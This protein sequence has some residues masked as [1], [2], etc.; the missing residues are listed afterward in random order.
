MGLQPMGATGQMIGHNGD[1]HNYGGVDQSVTY[2]VHPASDRD[3][4]RGLQEHQN[5]QRSN[6]ALA[7][8]PGTFPA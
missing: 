5:S 1:V 3:T 6:A 7:S 8:A 2:Q 4:V